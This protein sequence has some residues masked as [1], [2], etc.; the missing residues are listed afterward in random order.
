MNSL[1][2]R[3][4]AFLRLHEGVRLNAYRDP[5][6]IVTIGVGFTWRSAAFRSWWER[7]KAAPFNMRSSMT[8][9]EVDDALVYL[10][11]RE[12]GKAVNDFLG[13]PVKQHVFDAMT[14]A[15]FNLGPGA[16]KWKWAAAA[17]RGDYAEA[18]RLL[19]RTGT[20]AGGKRLA[21][22]VRR[23]KEEALLLEKGIYTG[24]KHA[25]AT[26]AP[27][28]PTSRPADK[29]PETSPPVRR[30]NIF[31]AMVEFLLGLFSKRST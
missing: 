5:V 15:V 3:G 12:Y 17:K 20:T 11:A 1:S 18:A 31:S 26:P 10:V 27:A 19:R 30:G 16:L 2:S 13:K 9:Q 24:V 7:N 14:S 4:A 29:K 28:Q 8:V 25:P 23:R 6:G 22:L 21:G